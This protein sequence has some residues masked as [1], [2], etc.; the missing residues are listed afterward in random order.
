MNAAALVILAITLAVSAI[1]QKM[2][3]TFPVLVC[4]PFFAAG[5]TRPEDGSTK[6]N[7]DEDA[8]ATDLH[9]AS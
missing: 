1:W 2:V 8:Q 6:R 3:Y 4:L 5:L 7:L 9:D